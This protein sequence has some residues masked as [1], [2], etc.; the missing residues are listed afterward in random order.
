MLWLCYWIIVLKSSLAQDPNPN[1]VSV[2]WGFIYTHLP[3]VASA[4]FRADEKV[5]LKLYTTCGGTYP[6]AISQHCW[7]LHILAQQSRSDGGRR[8]TQRQNTMQMQQLLAWWSSTRLVFA[9]RLDSSSTEAQWPPVKQDEGND[10]FNLIQE[11][12]WRD[13]TIAP[14]PPHQALLLCTWQA[15]QTP[16]RLKWS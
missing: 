1:K 12:I 7:R 2:R 4:T 13:A 14:K 11:N 16:H 8:I 5:Y 15:Q 10:L 6:S 9:N 3:K